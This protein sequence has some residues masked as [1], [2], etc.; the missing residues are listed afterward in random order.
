MLAGFTAAGLWIAN[1]NFGYASAVG[2]MLFLITAV[3]A[4]LQFRVMRADALEF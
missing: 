1:G 3:I 4:A 2:V